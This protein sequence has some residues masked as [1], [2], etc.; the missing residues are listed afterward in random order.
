MTPGGHCTPGYLCISVGTFLTQRAVQWQ[1]RCALRAVVGHPV[2]RGV[3]EGS[4]PS[5]HA[6]STSGLRGP[7][8][9]LSSKPHNDGVGPQV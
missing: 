3:I 6:V 5:A 9:E 8:V 2:V 7:S 4:F 1:R